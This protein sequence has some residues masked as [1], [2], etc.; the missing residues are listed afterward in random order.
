MIQVSVSK[1]HEKS[2]L[3]WSEFIITDLEFFP[4]VKMSGIPPRQ[5]RECREETTDSL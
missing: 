1:P 4:F 5:F 2:L 3:I